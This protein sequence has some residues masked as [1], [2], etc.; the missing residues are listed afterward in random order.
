MHGAEKLP[1]PKG[2]TPALRLGREFDEHARVMEFA[3]MR[4][5]I[6]AK[7]QLTTFAFAVR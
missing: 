5:A 2:S 4:D 6:A 3:G 7:G 1:K